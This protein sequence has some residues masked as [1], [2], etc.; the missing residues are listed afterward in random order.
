[1][2]KMHVAATQALDRFEARTAELK[3]HFERHPANYA[4]ETT[5]RNKLLDDYERR[6]AL[7]DYNFSAGEE[8]RMTARIAAEFQ[9][10][11]LMRI[12]Q[13]KD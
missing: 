10:R 3:K 8:A 13:F 11:Q 7:D 1:M 6:D 4:D 12:K 5:R 2:D 9:L